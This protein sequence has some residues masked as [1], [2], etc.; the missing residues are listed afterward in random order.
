MYI[1]GVILF[2]DDRRP[3]EARYDVRKERKAMAGHNGE[4]RIITNEDRRSTVPPVVH[5]VYI[6]EY[7]QLKR[8]VINFG[9]QYIAELSGS[10]LIIR[11]NPTPM[12]DVYRPILRTD[13][14]TSVAGLIGA[15]GAGKSTVCDLLAKIFGCG[16]SHSGD[17]VFGVIIW[18]EDG[19]LK[20]RGPS[21]LVD[22]NPDPTKEKTDPVFD[23][24]VIHESDNEV[25]ELK[26]QEDDYPKVD[27]F[28]L[29]NESYR[30]QSILIPYVNSNWIMDARTHAYKK[31][32]FEK[33]FNPDDKHHHHGIMEQYNLYVYANELQDI[34]R[35]LEFKSK[36]QA[37]NMADNS[38][39]KHLLNATHIGLFP[40]T[41]APAMLRDRGCFPEELTSIAERPQREDKKGFEEELILAISWAVAFEATYDIVN[42]DNRKDRILDLLSENGTS[43][44]NFDIDY[45]NRVLSADIVKRSHFAKSNEKRAF[46]NEVINLQSVKNGGLFIGFTD[47]DQSSSW[48]RLYRLYKSSLGLVPYIYPRLGVIN[49]NDNFSPYRPS[50]GEAI[51]SQV[52]SR[53][54]DSFMTRDE[55][56]CDFSKHRQLL[57]ILDDIDQG[58]NPNWQRRFVGDI[59]KLFAASGYADYIQIFL[60]THSPL[61]LTDIPGTCCN[62]LIRSDGLTTRSELI[63]KPTLGGNLFD[64]LEDQFMVSSGGGAEDMKKGAFIGTLSSEL[65]DFY[66]KNKPNYSR[67]IDALG[68]PILRMI[69]KKA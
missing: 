29:S 14:V 34:I 41:F 48:G 44:C 54:H 64:I 15:N 22:D 55:E 63:D 23:I 67:F 57:L 21:I 65:I 49:A 61:M 56:N 45:L 1:E 19:I 33:T 59:I 69:F 50:Y 38:I 31:R 62:C 10:K 47:N 53:M 39:F 6:H 8:C 60:T 7:R 46:F 9:T 37:M 52:L 32:D 43:P 17:D 35:W 13:C 28:Y 51:F 68:D 2:Q 20:A 5:A 11:D 40:M 16:C 12:I 30:D 42:E 27:A 25:L 18:E 36:I 4:I 58:F 3:F 66:L 26:I 24:K